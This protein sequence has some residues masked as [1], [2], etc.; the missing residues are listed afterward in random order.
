MIR[1]ILWIALLSGYATAQDVRVWQDSIRLPTYPELDPDPTPQFPAF[2]KDGP[3]NYPYP[4]RNG[5]TFDPATRKVEEWRT[6]NLENEYLSCR[7]LPDLGGRV[8]NCRD[9]VANKEVFYTNPVIKK[10]TFGL[11]GAWIATGIE[12]NFPVAH[13]RATVAPVNFAIREEPGAA[14]VIVADTDRVTG[15]QWRIEYRLRAGTAVLEERVSFYNPTQVRKP[16]Y[17]WNNAEV[18][19]DDP[20][21]RFILPTRAVASHNSTRIESWPK[22]LAGVDMSVVANDN[23]ETAWFAYDC[24]EPFMAV[25]KPAQRSGVAH[26]ADAAVVPGKKLYVMSPEQ[27]KDWR[28]QLTDNFHLY[29]EI[30]AGL[31]LNQETSEFLNPQQSKVFTE[32]WIPFR[33]LGGVSRVTPDA[34]LSVSRHM[35]K[36]QSTLALEVLATQAFRNARIVVSQGGR[37]VHSSTADL[38]PKAVWTGAVNAAAADPFHIRIADEK[39][40]ILLEHTEERYDASVPEGVTLGDQKARDWSDESHE[41]PLLARE[42]FRER[43]SMVPAAQNDVVAGLRRFPRSLGFELAAARLALFLDRFDEAALHANR[44]LARRLDDWEAA[45]IAGVA[46]AYLGDDRAAAALFRKVGG[47]SALGAA[48][49]FERAALAARAH[50]YAGALTLLSTLEADPGRAS[51]IVALEVAL[52]RRSGKTEAAADLFRRS[53]RL[54]PENT[55]LRVEGTRLGV[56][57][58]A[59]WSFLAGD[60]DRVLEIADDYAWFGLFED[61][62]ALTGYDFS[63]VNPHFLEPGA[64]PPSENPLVA[65][66]RAFYKAKFNEDP[67]ADLR[68]ASELNIR[69]VFPA[70]ASSA[71]ALRFAI[72]KNPSDANAHALLGDLALYALQPEQAIQEWEK[73]LSLNSKLAGLHAQIAATA[74]FLRAERA[75]A[76]ATKV[77]SP[78]AAPEKPVTPSVTDL[79]AKAMVLAASGSPVLALQAFREP[80]FAPE[81]LPAFVRMAYIEVQLQDIL[82]HS[83][84]R[85]CEAVEKQVF[86]LGNDNSSLPFTLGGFGPFMAAAH[87]QYYLGVAAANCGQT[88]QAVRYWSKAAKLKVAPSSPDFAYPALAAVKL[89]GSAVQS[90]VAGALAVLTAA[91]DQQNA[92]AILG[93]SLLQRAS[94]PGAPVVVNIVNLTSDPDPMVRY[95]ATTELTLAKQPPRR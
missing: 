59:L 45:F 42:D 84:K 3:P 70:R 36:G 9:K 50:D 4:V 11:R 76:A 33:S 61:A 90:T 52:L 51:R 1:G 93:K 54:H 6:L 19:Q 57:D 16:Y 38:N 46:Q 34:V 15:L 73:A 95:L 79:A 47:A 86:D 80:E 2:F 7:V 14:S 26:Y 44:A 5:V 28:Q 49:A 53:R 88:K 85:E 78:A 82:L 37:D 30:Q 56:A 10:Q 81:K 68:T 21:M 75:P 18:E 12:P 55:L 64:V 69:Y 66:H 71:A 48:A 20:G 92:A 17:W 13:S 77:L 25:Y 23:T 60:G 58:P 29:V 31:F 22:N 74:E 27:A 35:E 72:G 32:Y 24:R 43:S 40:R 83:V 39:G 67:T 41:L 8:Y 94:D 89:N 87:F 63:A 91:P 62:R 65:Y